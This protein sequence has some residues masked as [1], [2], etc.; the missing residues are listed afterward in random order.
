MLD[1]SK[2]EELLLRASHSAKAVKLHVSKVNVGSIEKPDVLVSY[3]GLPCG[4][5]II[6]YLKLENGVIKDTKFDYKGCVGTACSESALTSLIMGKSVEE[7]WKI[8]K[9]DVLRELD[10]LPESHYAKLAVNALRKALQKLKV[11]VSNEQERL[12]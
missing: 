2:I 5:T 1:R 12:S 11:K 9:E 10:G 6:L 7:A 8:A 3:T 4:D